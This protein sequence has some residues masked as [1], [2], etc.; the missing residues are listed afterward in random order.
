MSRF[1]AEFG[2]TALVAMDYTDVTGATNGDT[3]DMKGRRGALFVLH[4]HT[5]AAGTFTFKLQDSDDG[6][7]WADV[8]A[9]YVSESSNSVAFAAASEDDSVKQIGYHGFERYV[10]C[11]CTP[12]GASSTNYL[13]ASVVVDE[14]YAD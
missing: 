13:S 6:S 12:S 2:K 5:M 1:D 3:I 10:R 11:V 7:T 4:G 9:A 14:N 8:A